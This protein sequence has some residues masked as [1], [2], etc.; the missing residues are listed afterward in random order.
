MQQIVSDTDRKSRK[1]RKDGKA[2]MGKAKHLP[3]CEFPSMPS[4]RRGSTQLL[5][6][7]SIVCV[8]KP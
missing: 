2:G 3:V 4:R 8:G 5:S 7:K 6:G 1:S